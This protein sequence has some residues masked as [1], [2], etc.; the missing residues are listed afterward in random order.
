MYLALFETT[1]ANYDIIFA[2]AWSLEFRIPKL[3]SLLIKTLVIKCKH[4]YLKM[5][6]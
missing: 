3:L 6:K 2:F 1:E 5:G 4:N